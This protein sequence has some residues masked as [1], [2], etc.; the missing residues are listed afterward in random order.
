M[1]IK[2]YDL[3]TFNIHTH[4]YGSS[5]SIEALGLKFLENS[6]HYEIGI[7]IL[8]ILHIRSFRFRDSTSKM[9]N[10]LHALRHVPYEQLSSRGSTRE[11]PRIILVELTAIQFILI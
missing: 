2:R 11:R 6:V 9:F 10:Y 5:Y 3:K 4:Y 1:N 7:T 8:Y